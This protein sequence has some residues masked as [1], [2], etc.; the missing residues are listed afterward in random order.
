VRKA[1]EGWQFRAASVRDPATVCWSGRSGR[2]SLSTTTRC[3]SASVRPSRRARLRSQRIS[4]SVAR[5]RDVVW[6]GPLF[7]GRTV[8]PTDK[9]M[10]SR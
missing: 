10:T 5:H 7:K 8:R 3:C 9:F 6:P 4:E 1:R 2:G